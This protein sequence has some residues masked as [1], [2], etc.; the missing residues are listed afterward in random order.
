MVVIH[1]LR[2]LLVHTASPSYDARFMNA[3]VEGAKTLPKF[4]WKHIYMYIHG[5]CIVSVYHTAYRY[6]MFLHSC[7]SPGKRGQEYL[8]LAYVPYLETYRLGCASCDSAVALDLQV[9]RPQLLYAYC[10]H[11]DASRT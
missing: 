10:A 3:H 1:T 8:L 5:I 11:V 4:G 7:N 9:S 6:I 2:W